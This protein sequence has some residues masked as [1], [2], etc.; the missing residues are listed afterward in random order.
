MI[1]VIDI[2]ERTELMSEA[3]DY[4]WKNWGEDSNFHFYRDCIEQ[5]CKAGSD[6][7]RFY[8]AMRDEQIIGS[9][10]LLRSELNSRQ[11]LSPWIACLYVEPAE[12]GKQIGALLQEHAVQQTKEIGY[13]RLYLGTD[14]TGYY[15]RTNW[16]HIGFG[17]QLDNEQTRVYAYEI[18]D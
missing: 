14:L 1:R 2:R 5:S 12:R 10:A 6:L 8:L 11:D 9:Y 3:V 7:P 4:F 16:K 15:E 17:Y 18:E 13:S